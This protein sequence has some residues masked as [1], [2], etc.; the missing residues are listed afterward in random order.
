MDFVLKIKGDLQAMPNTIRKGDTTTRL[1][2]KNGGDWVVEWAT[3]VGADSGGSI[4]IKCQTTLPGLGDIDKPPESVSKLT[5][6][7]R[8]AVTVFFKEMMSPEIT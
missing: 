1:A 7:F 6:R 3:E 5:Q 4:T 8:E 2:R